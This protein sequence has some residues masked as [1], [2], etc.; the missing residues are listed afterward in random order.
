VR[1]R[2][3]GVTKMGRSAL[4]R[5]NHYQGQLQTPQLA[6]IPALSRLTPIEKG[7]QKH[8]YICNIQDVSVYTNISA[9][10]IFRPILVRPSSG[11]IP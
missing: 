3:L 8:N 6:T 5:T 2:W 1:L 9:N 10:Y 7:S 11:W 4:P